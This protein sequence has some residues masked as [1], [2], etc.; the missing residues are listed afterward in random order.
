MTELY[1]NHATDQ[2]KFEKMKSLPMLF[3]PKGTGKSP[4]APIDSRDEKL[5]QILKNITSEN[6]ELKRIEAIELLEDIG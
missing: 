4:P 2:A 5:L 3:N 6:L 1:A